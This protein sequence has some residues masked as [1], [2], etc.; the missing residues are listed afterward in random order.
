M[1]R[2]KAV[3]FP[4][5]AGL[6][7]LTLS[8][9][10]WAAPLSESSRHLLDAVWRNDLNAVQKAI[11]EGADPAVVDDDGLSAV[12]IAVDKGYFDIAHYL[13]AAQEQ[14]ED[15]ETTGETQAPRQNMGSAPLTSVTV[16]PL[17]GQTLVTEAGTEKKAQAESSASDRAPQRAEVM[18]LRD[19]KPEPIVVL[20]EVLEADIKK[21]ENTGKSVSSSPEERT[22][23]IISG[24][25]AA[26]EPKSLTEPD[27]K[28]ATNPDPDIHP[29]PVPLKTP[30][31][32]SKSPA[33]PVQ[34][35]IDDKTNATLEVGDASSDSD[36]AS[37]SSTAETPSADQIVGPDDTTSQWNLFEK[38]ENLF[39]A[40]VAPEPD[41][42]RVS[43]SIDEL[44]TFDP[45]A[46]EP[47]STVIDITPSA[48]ALEEPE[49]APTPGPVSRE[50]EIQ[51]AEKPGAVNPT[52]EPKI[53]KS[54]SFNPF[55]E[56]TDFILRI[57]PD[58]KKTED[59]GV[60]E[61]IK[62]EPDIGLDGQLNAPKPLTLAPE[63]LK[64][65]VTD[66]VGAKNPYAPDPPTASDF[67][68]PNGVPNSA[69]R[70]PVV[71]LQKKQTEKVSAPNPQLKAR[72]K[73]PEDSLL[74][75]DRGLI[76]LSIEQAGVAREDCVVKPA[77]R[78]HFCL[79]VLSWPAEVQPAFGTPSFFIG[80]GTTIVHYL[81]GNAVQYHGTFPTRSFDII[82]NHLISLYG[83]PTAVP[84]IMTAFLAEP[85]RRN[86]AFQWIATAQNESPEIVMEI[87]KIDDLR[88]SSPPDKDNGVI[89]M[90]RQGDKSVFRL[91]SAADLLLLQ[92]RKGNVK[93]L[94][95]NTEIPK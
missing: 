7:S 25:N 65:K 87:R 17:G 79:Q 46:P 3:I 63:P 40:D 39:S 27:S 61:A 77:W 5:M 93:R 10:L 72:A 50:P 59:V 92:V 85:K 52:L 56:L 57:L 31:A 62:V 32:A 11:G 73:L 8:H 60:N 75:G 24:A 64:Y 83:E 84:E 28:R 66:L 33:E 86:P 30:E 37:Q 20:P 4:I 68:E 9:A 45:N 71:R 55:T 76:N 82:K 43:S 91:L 23:D 90:Y 12:D 16:V 29:I 48:N 21:L 38:I 47:P 51:G 41:P 34:Q 70:S 78:S 54:P 35:I 26:P 1:R 94:P 89:R 49:Q 15:A 95:S 81:D 80:G 58:K 19:E 2:Y 74:F 36:M 69:S 22:G 67:D 6:V 44:E 13:L 14:V 42:Q 88:W 18:E 53:E